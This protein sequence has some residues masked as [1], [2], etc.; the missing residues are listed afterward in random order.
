MAKK[1]RRLGLLHLVLLMQMSTIVVHAQVAPDAGTVRQEIETKRETEIPIEPPPPTAQALP[2]ETPPSGPTVTV[3]SFEFSGNVLMD[4]QKLAVATAGFVARPV[5]FSE[6]QKA[7]I[8]VADAYRQEGWI[9]QAF[10][11]LQEINNG[12]VKI[13][14][15]EALFGVARLEGNQPRRITFE[16]LSRMIDAQQRRGASLAVGAL[17]R[18]LLLINDLPGVTATGNLSPG[19]DE[20]ETDLLLKVQDD[21]LLSGE[22]IIDNAGS[23]FTG[24]ERFIGTVSLNSPFRFGE[25]LSATLLYSEGTEYAQLAANMPIGSDG[26]R[27]GLNVSHL[28]YELVAPEFDALNAKG[29]STAFGTNASYPLIRARAAS[30]NVSVSYENSRFE[31]EA[32]D[33]TSTRYKVDTL[34]TNLNGYAFDDWGGGG[35][36]RAA[37]AITYGTVDLTGSPNELA[38]AATTKADGGFGK[39]NYFVSRQQR[40]TEIFS[41]YAAV[42]GQLAGGNLESSEKFYLGGASAIR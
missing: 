38:V 27:V 21:R 22:V 11:P 39:A 13:Q 10:L 4:S 37:L 36:S 35:F 33:I 28:G 1:I 5:D 29:S 19:K 24:E 25:Q 40:V 42:S 9:V 6:L 16:R 17:D 7:P 41:A 18:G 2:V 20:R 30:L 15:V 32:N 8:A 34:A 14:I 12:V 31:N 26:W 23:R 3:S